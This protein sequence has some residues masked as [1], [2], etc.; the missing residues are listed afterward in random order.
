MFSRMAPEL[1]RELVCDVLVDLAQ[2]AGRARRGHTTVDLVFVDGAFQDG[3]AP[4]RDL[5]KDVLSWWQERGCLPEMT[6]LHGAL[7]HALADYTGFSLS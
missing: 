6:R 7:V 4:W 5:V 3:Q 1:R 2:L